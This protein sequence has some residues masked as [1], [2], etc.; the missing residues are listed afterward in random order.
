MH[1]FKFLAEKYDRLPK[2]ARVFVYLVYLF[3][4]VYLAL[5]PQFITAKVMVKV[6]GGGFLPYRGTQI[7]MAVEGHVM[8][9]KTNEYGYVSLPL[10]SKFPVS[11]KLDI[12]DKD[13]RS[14][15]S[16][17]VPVTSIFGFN[18]LIGGKSV[19]IMMN[20]SGGEPVIV[21]DTETGAVGK[22]SRGFALNLIGRAVAAEKDNSVAEMPNLESLYKVLPTS[23]QGSGLILPPPPPSLSTMTPFQ[24][25]ST[26]VPSQILVPVRRIVGDL[27]GKPGGITGDYA[28]GRGSGLRY[29]QRIQL[30]EDV[31]LEFDFKIPDEHWQSIST[32]GELEDYVFSRKELEEVNPQMRVLGKTPDWSAV[33]K[34]FPQGGMPVF[35]AD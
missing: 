25:P 4:L 13:S 18:A 33:Q 15:F 28:I 14:W 7:Q 29:I 16:L 32:V 6:P 34:I 20:S 3:L 19:G 1:V 30:I 11:V 9:F 21:G 24:P 8:R 2:P 31:E 22:A 12:F 5:A 35:K 23:R 10:V 27:A 26:A 17:T